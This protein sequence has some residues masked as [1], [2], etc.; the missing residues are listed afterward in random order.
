MVDQSHLDIL[1][2]GVEAW[3]EWREQNPS[4]MPDL[5]GA[6]LTGADLNW[7]DLSKTD[8]IEAP[9]RGGPH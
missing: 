6:D 1:L 9:R 4:I 8:L 3:N 5:S 2:Q 7:V